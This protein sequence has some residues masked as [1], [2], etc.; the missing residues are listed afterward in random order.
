MR[1]RKWMARLLS[2][3]MALALAC[4]MFP[5]QNLRAAEIKDGEEVSDA[6][7]E[8]SDTEASGAE[9]EGTAKD[10]EAS[11]AKGERTEKNTE[12]SGTKE[13]GTAKNTETSGKKEDGTAKESEASDAE[14][15]D[16]AGAEEEHPQEVVEI[17]TVEDFLAFGNQCFIDSWSANKLVFLNEDIDLTGTDF[18]AIPVF[19]GTFQGQGHTISGFSYKGSG[20]VAGLFRYIEKSGVVEDLKLKGEVIAS[21]EKECIGSLCGVNYGTIKNCSFQGNVSG[22]TTV[23]GLVGVNEGTGTI[24]NSYAGGRVTG[25]YSTGGLVGKN[26]GSI[27]RCANRTCVNNDSQWVEEDDEM[28]VGI[29][30]SINISDS[31]T[32]MFSGVD[33][34]GIAGYSDG[35]ITRCINY[36]RV[37]YEHTGYNI[38]GIAGRQSGIVSFCTNDGAVYGRKDVG[39]IVGQMEPFIEVDEATSLRSA[40]DKLHELIEKTID[41]ME[42][43]KNA[44][45]EDFDKL[46]DYSDGAADAGDALA[47]QIADFVDGNMEQAQL[48]TDR[49]GHV[50]D[51]LPDVF[52]DIYEAEDSFSKING[53]LSGMFDKLGSIGDISGEYEETDY[54]R[55][56]LLSTVGG[57]ILSIQHYPKAGESVHIMVEPDKDYGLSEIRAIDANGNG[58]PMQRESGKDYTFV[59]PEPNVKVEA[60][61][62]YQ[63]EK[64][65]VDAAGDGS[66]DGE[67]GADED[68]NADGM[69]GIAGPGGNAPSDNAGQPGG[70]APSDNTGQPGGNTPSDNAGQPGGNAPSDNAGQPGGNSPSDNS[71]R[72]NGSGDANEGAPSGNPGQPGEGSTSGG[73]NSSGEAG[74]GNGASGGI[75]PGENGS[76]NGGA[77]SDNSGQ[78]G[79]TSQPQ[80]SAQTDGNSQARAFGNLNSSIE[81]SKTESG[82]YTQKMLFSEGTQSVPEIGIALEDVKSQESNTVT[83]QTPQQEEGKKK[84]TAI[85][86]SSNLS[87]SASWEINGS[88]ATVTVIPD[89]AYTVSK[90]PSVTESGQGIAVSKSEKSEYAYTFEVK[91]GGFYRVDITFEKRDKSQS[92][93]SAKENIN[94]ALKAQQAAAEKVNAVM[95]EIQESGSASAEQLNRLAE[96]MAEM[97]D[98]ASAVMSNLNVVMNIAGQQASDV[99]E[100]VGGDMKNV[101]KHLQDVT[102]SVKSA[103]RDVRSIVDYVNGQSDIRFSKLGAEFDVNR[104][105]LRSQLKGMSESLKGLSGNASNYSDIVNDDLRAVNHQINVIFNILA[106]NIVNYNDISIEELYKDIDLEDIESI[107]TGKTDTCTNRG[108]VKGDINIG[109]IAGAMSIDEEDPEDSAAG[110]VDYQIGRRYFTKCIITDSVNEGYITAK[111]DGAGGIVGYMMHCIVVDSE[112]YGS[113]ESTE[114]SYVG[115]ICG[116]SFTMI[117]GCYAL[118]AVSGKKNVGGIAGFADTV[119][120]CYAM[121]DCS[122]STGRKG[123]IAGQTVDYDDALN[124]EEVKVSG[125]YYVGENLYGI[126]D[127]SYAGIAEPISYEELLQK[128]GL[129]QEFRHLKVIFRVEDAYLGTQEVAFGDSLA[130]LEYPEIPEREG[131]YGIWPDCSDKMMTGNLLV[132]GE[133]KEDVTVVESNEKQEADGEAGYEKPYALVEQRFTENTVLRAAISDSEPPEAV[134]GKEYVVYDIALE[135][136]EIKDADTFAVRLYNPYKDAV[137][138]GCKDGIWRELESKA[139]GEYLQVDMAG[140]EQIFCIVQQTSSLWIIIAGTAGGLVL[141][142]LL[143]LVGKKRK[144]FHKK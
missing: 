126:D 49:I 73:G 47:E 121:V 26:H 50:T 84:A 131:Y 54:N 107:T 87:G 122:A 63:G 124:E 143:V 42:N 13:E 61:F 130:G 113:V 78:P 138:W 105:N 98:A 16:T 7:K 135:N 108:I 24:L 119:K 114:G 30:L 136:V 60:Y 28:G 117:K 52:D 23:G 37:G 95:K 86:L 89:G 58:I 94:N 104:E 18:E 91:E 88:S 3:G 144:R 83:D 132:E 25:Y 103:T 62:S 17:N 40:V 80:E 15:E 55:L 41:D 22:R 127:I 133:Y 92:V 77:P 68:E 96:G 32:E 1:Y 116:E 29:F 14:G 120:D 106:D 109:G 34:G 45:K 90:T 71:G 139:R 85:E 101:A 102:D 66:I 99:L 56:S 70:S 100:A 4:N 51:M 38:G 46:A 129:P 21:D 39:G 8:V 79:E 19:A 11:G 44:V 10:A 48:V 123:A 69:N 57:S 140:T 137:V 36:G 33:A 128:E 93:G 64:G 110:K 31:E 67:M 125:N 141:V 9:E 74:G 81:I 111:K 134:H 59:M 75:Q 112:G 20:Y 115:G 65:G 2:M 82:Q 5:M 35:L 76:G 43:A 97:S 6:G 72:P 12:A 27:S 118:C 53:D 142:A